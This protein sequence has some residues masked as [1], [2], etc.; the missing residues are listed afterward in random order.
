MI[1]RMG[2]ES[3]ILSMVVSIK[4]I[5]MMVTSMDKDTYFI[6]IMQTSIEVNGIMIRS[7]VLDK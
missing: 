1:T 3:T 6:G 4:G 5:G 7:I 2:K